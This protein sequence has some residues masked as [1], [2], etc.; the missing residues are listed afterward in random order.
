M[1][2]LFFCGTQ[3]FEYFQRISNFQVDEKKTKK[4]YLGRRNFER[5]TVIISRSNSNKVFSTKKKAA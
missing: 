5:K 2:E 1:I 4:I 3:T